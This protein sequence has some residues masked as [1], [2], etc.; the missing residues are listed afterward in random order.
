MSLKDDIKTLQAA[1]MPDNINGDVSP[2]DVRDALALPLDNL[3]NLGSNY[4]G[5][6]IPTDTAPIGVEEGAT[7]L[8]T[9]DGH[10]PNHNG[11]IKNNDLCVFV[12]T[13]GGWVKKPISINTG[14]VSI[15]E[16]G[17]VSGEKVRRAL[18]DKAYGKNLFN[19]EDAEIINGKM[20]NLYGDF[21]TNASYFVTGFMNVAEGVVYVKNYDHSGVYTNF[22][23]SKFEKI[24]IGINTKSFTIPIGVAY[25]RTT[26]LLANKDA[27]QF[28]I[29]NT[30]TDYEPYTEL[31]NKIGS[32]DLKDKAVVLG[33]VADEAIIENNTVFFETS[34]NLFNINDDGI[35]LDRFISYINGDSQSNATYNSTGY[36]P[37]VAGQT[38]T[39]SYEHQMAFYD[40][41]KVYISGINSGENPTFTA[42]LLSAY[43]RCTVLKAQW[44]KFQLESGIF[45]TSYVDYGL[46]IKEKYLQ[47]TS[48]EILSTSKQYV[49]DNYENTKY[50]NAMCRRFRPQDESYRIEG[51]EWKNRANFA[52]IT[53]PTI[54]TTNVFAKIYDDEFNEIASSQF[55]VVVGN[56]ATDNG[57]VS[58]V[59]IGDSLSYNGSYIAKINTLL[60]NISWDGIRLSYAG[61][62]NGEGRGG[63]T[64]DNYFNH[65]IGSSIDSF[66][67]FMHP[68]DPYKYFGGSD[69][70]KAVANGATDYG[71]NGFQVKAAEIGFS[72]STGLL[73]T[74]SINDCMYNNTNSRYERW[75][76]SAWVE[77]LE[78]TLNFSFNFAKYRSTWNVAQPD[79]VSIMIGTNDFRNQASESAIDS[80]WDA[81]KTQM[82]T[83]IT[84][85][86]ADNP[87]A[88]IAIMIA[89]TVTG[90]ADNLGGYFTKKQDAMM[91]Y[92]RRRV[93]SDFDNR[94]S[95]SIYLVDAGTS[96][97]SLYGMVYDY[98]LPFSDFGENDR[99]LVQS[100][101]PHPSS[102]G[103]YQLGIPLA[104]W[105]QSVR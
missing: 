65:L 44:G 66:T 25:I 39:R 17:G 8:P 105:I 22:Y 9:V 62:V 64:L 27:S 83:L 99:L 85:V 13:S 53:N 81:W 5:T 56:Q 100:N 38:Y 24:T 102:R 47:P 75:N 98:E 68:I 49:L 71:V 15:G 84:S 101:T 90:V 95:E 79:I 91:W 80:F 61:L 43:C 33:N 103:Y 14:T 30:S 73:S 96:L 52:R 40:S 54:S 92:S 59:F 77:I 34:K 69:F 74:P 36:I 32:K 23:N 16:S 50:F 6:V 104:A 26:Y 1:L 37:I 35:E 55:D 58:G 63:W 48:N 57:S 11:L 93:I 82:E 3:S 29:G 4:Y 60:P 31:N 20:I 87:A 18:I 67:P 10:Y 70:W 78:A 94:E 97:D 21:I 76:G 51:G 45:K 28:E 19:R 89:P 12:Y 88:K 72:L 2:K 42:P 7:L 86:I 41:S 46:F